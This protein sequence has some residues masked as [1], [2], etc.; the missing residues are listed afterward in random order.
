MTPTSPDE[1]N[2]IIQ[3]AQRYAKEILSGAVTPYEGG[4]RIWRDCQLKLEDGDH[5]LDPFVYWAS[6]YEETTSKPRRALCGK[7]LRNAATLLVQH[8]SAL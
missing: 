5:R 8:G 2:Q 7:A 6:E 1:S 3:E 4:H